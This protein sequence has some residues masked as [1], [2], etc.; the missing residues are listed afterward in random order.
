MSY[1]DTFDHEYLADLGYLPIY[2]PLVR[3]DGG[4]WGSYD[5]SATPENLILGGGCGEHPGLVLHNLGSVAATFVYAQL[6]EEEEDTLPQD[7]QHKL[8]DLFYAEGR[9][10]FCSWS[11]EQYANL[12]DMAQSPAMSTP[13]S[14]GQKVEDW[15]I[16]SLGEFIWFSLPDLNPH[17]D[18]LLQVLDGRELPAPIRNVKCHPPGYPLCA[19]RHIING[20]L[21]WGNYRWNHYL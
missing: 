19:G 1:I 12:R 11:I 3:V 17:Q 20:K 9:L 5:F 14:D 21:K 2:R 15:L 13:L 16:Q 8:L 10:E 4:H 6:T 18:F 7:T